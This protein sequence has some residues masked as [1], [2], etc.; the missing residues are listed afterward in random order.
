MTTLTSTVVYPPR[1]DAHLR[2]F[3]LNPSYYR[4]LLFFL[5][6]VPV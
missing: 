5:P 1:T 3:L 6:Y 4:A 2:L